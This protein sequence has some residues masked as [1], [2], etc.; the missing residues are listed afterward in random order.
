MG[1]TKVQFGLAAAAAVFIAG[2]AIRLPAQPDGTIATRPAGSK[3]EVVSIQAATERPRDGVDV[4]ADGA[5]MELRCW[6]L[7]RLIVKAYG[8]QDCRLAGTDGM[9][10][11][12]IPFD[13]QATLPPGT[14]P[15]DIPEMLQAMLSDRFGLKMHAETRNLRGFSL[16]VA[17]GGP[18]I[19]PAAEPAPDREPDAADLLADNLKAWGVSVFG[20]TLGGNFRM[21]FDA[22]P[23]GR[24]TTFL[25][26]H[27]GA[28][29]ADRTG[30]AG[31]YQ[32]MLEYDPGLDRRGPSLRDQGG[33]D[34]FLAVRRLGLKLDPQSVRTSVLVV[35]RLET[36]PTAN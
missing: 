31:D 18:K 5:R 22:L 8:I 20:R 35:D 36:T 34:L 19:Q 17:K 11:N 29:V 15:K 16:T 3:F 32:V 2:V 27:L 13:I 33:S 10:L 26:S 30:L 9:G 12:D 7:M 28:P 23:M 1:R 24:L 25:E 14:A 4:R 21:K 6:S